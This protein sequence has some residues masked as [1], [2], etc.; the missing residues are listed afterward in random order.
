MIDVS[1]IGRGPVVVFV[2]GSIVGAESTWRHQRPLAERW[3]L[4]LANRPG[5][6][7]SP[8]LARGDFE[9]EAPLIAEQLGEGA[10]LV[11]HSYG[12]VVALYAALLRPDAVRSLT[13]SEPGALRLAAGDP[14]VDAAIA[15]GL[16]LYRR[17]DEVTP[18]EFL[19]LFRMGVGSTH[20]T[21]SELPE[22]LRRGVE[23]LMSERP[24]WEA[25][26][27]VDELARAPF[28]KLVIS[29]GHS[30]VFEAVCD[31]LA[32]G[33]GAQRAII[34]GRGHTIPACGAAYN[35]RLA[36]F[37]EESERRLTESE[38]T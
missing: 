9:L 34:P 2:H 5:F 7:A 18:R 31:A 15:H 27:A 30:D 14:A 26:I 16:E 1:T 28:A 33:V 4:C 11:G 17:R 23:L 3:T 25:E 12:A 8:A 22:Q 36:A 35:E 19:E 32:S 20:Q 21:P 38:S 29:G 6:G 10:H 37:L 13:V 24:P